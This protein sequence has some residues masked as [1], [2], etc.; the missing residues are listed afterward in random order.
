M[1]TYFKRLRRLTG[2]AAL[3]AALY[4]ATL[5]A[6]PEVNII[7]P[8]DGTVPIE[9]I[10]PVRLT[11][12]DSDGLIDEVEIRL[13]GVTIITYFWNFP[14][15]QWEIS[16][17]LHEFATVNVPPFLTDVQIPSIGT[18]T[19]QAWVRSTTGAE[20]LSNVVNLTGVFA[21]AGTEPTVSILAPFDGSEYLPGTTLPVLVDAYVP[22]AL[23]S[24][25]EFLLNGVV[26]DT[27][28]SPPYISEVQLPSTGTFV[29]SAR[30]TTTEN[31]SAFSN[32][33]SLDAQYNPAAPK[34]YISQPLPLGGGDVINDV[35]VASSMFL[36]AVVEDDGGI[37]PS[38][39]VTFYVNGFPMGSPASMLGNVYSMFF[40][41]YSTGS[42]SIMATVEDADGNMG[43]SIPLP[44]DVGLLERPLPQGTVSKIDSPVARGEPIDLFV[45]TQGY[46]IPIDRVDFYANGIFIGNSDTP[47]S[48]DDVTG[49]DTFTFRWTPPQS[50]DYE[51]RSRLV[52]IDPA[53]ATYDNWYITEAV[54]VTVEGYG[55]I[56]LDGSFND[57]DYSGLVGD[58]ITFTFAPDGIEDIQQVQLLLGSEVIGTSLTVPATFTYTPEVAG[59]YVFMLRV[60]LTDGTVVDGEPISIIVDYPDPLSENADFVYQVILDLLKRVPSPE[61]QADYVSRID[62]GSLTRSRFIREII[63]PAD[64]Q[65]ESE[66]DAVRN[67]LLAYRMAYGQWPDIDTLESLTKEVRDGGLTALVATLIP[68]LESRYMSDT[69]A[70]GVPDK[71][72]VIS[73]I[74]DFVTYLFNLKFAADPTAKQLDLAITMFQVSDRNQYISDFIHN[75]EVIAAGTTYYVWVFTFQGTAPDM[76]LLRQADVAS[77]YINFLKNVPD[78]S[79]IA[80]KAEMAFEVFVDEALASRNYSNRFVSTFAQLE[81]RSSGWKLSEWL[82]YFNTSFEPWI[83]HSELGWVSFSVTGQDEQNLWMYDHALGWVWTQ[84]G[85]YPNLFNANSGHWLYAA[86]GAYQPGQLRWFFDYGLQD[87]IQR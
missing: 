61:E 58:P 38:D 80:E 54:A 4:G 47:S 46:L 87:W 2:A 57:E 72:S 78:D 50:G 77:I 84:V 35:S 75:N 81:N 51:I 69:G 3:C 8:A 48:T 36:N 42:Y 66:Y 17:Y 14:A 44:L 21:G 62:G 18:Y 86:G 55:D 71:L 59:E 74:A 10:V 30:A 6:V 9:T 52:Q 26:V 11:A 39:S 7:T 31:A 33:V 28:T 45:K 76:S 83:Y 64:G 23:I 16:Q 27:V 41:P 68:A 37:V 65:A 13:N 12:Y 63:D 25:V 79:V 22:D 5:Q 19:L 1:K 15:Q 43:Y 24:D 85:T 70:S 60:T 29:L 82:G 56:I 53:D 20:A 67:A 40:S 34:I 73:E 49:E 32:T